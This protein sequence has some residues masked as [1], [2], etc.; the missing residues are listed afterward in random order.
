M[1]DEHPEREQTDDD[2]RLAKAYPELPSPEPQCDQCAEPGQ[3]RSHDTG[4][5]PGDLKLGHRPKT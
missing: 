4:R 2:A 3:D 5:D 1:A